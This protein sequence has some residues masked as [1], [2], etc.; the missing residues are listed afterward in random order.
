ML[1]PSAPRVSPVVPQCTV[2][3]LSNINSESK[4]YTST[5]DLCKLTCLLCPK[6]NLSVPCVVSHELR[7][8]SP[9][10]KIYVYPVGEPPV[11]TPVPSFF[12]VSEPPVASLSAFDNLISPIAVTK[13]SARLVANPTAPSNLSASAKPFVPKPFHHHQ[14][15]LNC[16]D[17]LIQTIVH[18]FSSA[19]TWGILSA[20]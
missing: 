9:T 2:P 20:L 3:V 12:P 15:K 10:S 6:L 8:L 1:P 7:L 5:E 18:P 4:L 19:S 13:S 16:L 11:S 14:Y 17:D